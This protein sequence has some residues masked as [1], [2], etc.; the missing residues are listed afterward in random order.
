[1]APSEGVIHDI[2]YQRYTGPRLG[3]RY[4]SISLYTSSLRTAFGLGRTAKSKIFPFVIAGL[5]FAVAAI[6]V[7]LRSQSGQVVITYLQ[8]CDNIGIP[9]LLF[10]A[11]VAPELV[12][13]DLRAKTLPLYFSRPLSRTDYA[14]AKLFAMVSAMWLVLAGPL[15]VMFLGGVFSQTKGA[16]GAWHE[17]LDFLGGLGYAAMYAIIFSSVAVLVASLAGRRAVAAAAIV[18]VFLVTAPIVG[19]LQVIGG[20]AIRQ[21]SRMLNPVLL[22]Q[23]LQNWIFRT[24]TMNIQ[25]YG[26]VY[27]AASVLLVGACGLLLVMRYRKVAA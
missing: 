10:L 7:V 21:V 18:G 14:L 19:V 20:P 6:A 15:M 3:R 16:S 1:M 4:A 23:G 27:L 9:L 2:G 8:F 13:R 12:S 26:P 25:G 22:L 5:A 11:V 24:H 17:V